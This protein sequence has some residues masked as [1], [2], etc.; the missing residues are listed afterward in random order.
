MG[1]CVLCTVVHD[2]LLYV[3]NLGDC[4]A[5]L[6]R[7]QVT[8]LHNKEV[9][10]SYIP[11]KLS[12]TFNAGKSYEQKKLREKF[13]DSDIVVDKGVACYVKGRLQ[14]TRSLGDFYMKYKE[15]NN[16]PMNIE[17]RYL[18]RV[19]EN[20]NGPYIESEPDIQVFE[21]CE[22]DE[23]LILS[24]D[25]LWDWLGSKDVAEIIKKNKNDKSHIAEALLKEALTRAASKANLQIEQVMEMPKSVKRSIHDDISLLVVDLK[26]QVTYKNSTN[27]HSHKG[28]I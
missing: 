24:T 13:K 25:G 26:N 12:I 2:N 22:E 14:P 23:F 8:I 9:E 28:Q 4:K 18:R 27:C 19:I 3:A 6:F 21:L 16:P 20:F 11:I 17:E 1:S 15:F 10:I 5:I 7:K